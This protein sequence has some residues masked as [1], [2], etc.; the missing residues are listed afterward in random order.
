MPVKCRKVKG[1]TGSLCYDEKGL[2]NGRKKNNTDNITMPKKAPR[3][4]TPPRR[5]RTPTRKTVRKISTAN[6]R[7]AAKDPE[8]RSTYRQRNPKK[9]G[10]AAYQRYEKYKGAGSVAQAMVLGARTEDIQYDGD[11]RFFDSTEEAAPPNSLVALNKAAA[12]PR[13]PTISEGD[14][15]KFMRRKALI[16]DTASESYR[17]PRVTVGAANFTSR[18]KLGQAPKG[19]R[20]GFMNVKSVKKSTTINNRG[21]S[22]ALSSMNALH[23]SANTG[24]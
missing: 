1:R 16:G 18:T 6:V 2:L 11:R 5:A 21:Q 23:S 8:Q 14:P 19:S 10:S 20:A 24:L 12:R 4:K 22:G 3:S 7:A 13:D 17:P 15:G 9:P